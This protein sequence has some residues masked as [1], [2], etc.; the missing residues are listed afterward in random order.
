MFPAPII[1]APVD[2]SITLDKGHPQIFFKNMY[3]YYRNVP[4]A[5][6]MGGVNVRDFFGKSPGTLTAFTTPPDAQIVS[7]GR[8][9]GWGAWNFNGTSAYINVPVTDPG[10]AVVVG[11]WVCPTSVVPGNR[12]TLFCIGTS[13]YSYQLFTD[14]STWQSYYHN[15]LGDNGVTSA[16]GLKV[17]TWTHVVGAYLNITGNFHALYINGAKV[18]SGTVSTGLPRTRTGGPMTIGTEFADFP[19]SGNWFWQGYIDDVRI[20]FTNDMTDQ[21]VFN[22]YQLSKRGDPGLLRRIT[23][24]LLWPPPS[25]QPALVPPG[26]PGGVAVQQNP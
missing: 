11:M 21:S 14:G 24:P 3:G 2:P 25:Y 1:A 9:G 13:G 26:L 5:G 19:P 16:V 22:W 23:D 7:A 15:I 20:F 8:P 6:R 12:R 4:N 10:F 17:N 18:A